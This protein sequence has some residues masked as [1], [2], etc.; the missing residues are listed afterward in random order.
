MCATSA[1]GVAGIVIG[2]VAVALYFYYAKLIE[3]LSQA[4]AAIDLTRLVY[5]HHPARAWRGGHG[6]RTWAVEHGREDEARDQPDLMRWRVALQ[7]IVLCLVMRPSICRPNP[8]RFSPPNFPILLL[9]PLSGWP[10]LWK[11]YNEF[12]ISL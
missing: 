6:A 12:F 7:F 8:R 3:T 9:L 11:T 1:V 10:A 4:A 5:F 2:V